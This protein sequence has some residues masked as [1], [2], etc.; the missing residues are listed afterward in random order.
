MIGSWLFL[1]ISFPFFSLLSLC[2]VLG[3]PVKIG[4][5]FSIIVLVQ[6]E[7]RVTQITTLNIKPLLFWLAFWSFS[8]D[9]YAQTDLSK[10][11]LISANCMPMP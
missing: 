8:I 1:E 10:L 9:F 11:V 2:F 5:L 3:P 7:S 6:V 4:F